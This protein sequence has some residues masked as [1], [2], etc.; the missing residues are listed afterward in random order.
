[1]TDLGAVNK[2]KLIELIKSDLSSAGL[3][4][5]RNAFEL[6]INSSAF[7][8]KRESFSTTLLFD[9]SKTIVADGTSED[10]VFTADLTNA[11]EGN[12]TAISLPSGTA[13]SI[14]FTASEFEIRRNDFD[15]AVD[16]V[17]Y[18]SYEFGKIAVSILPNVAA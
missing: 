14:D 17:A 12:I 18:C 16:C 3:N 13:N 4:E 2:S 5:T 8:P 6:L 10:Y 15:S 7:N 1:M 11:A 9:D